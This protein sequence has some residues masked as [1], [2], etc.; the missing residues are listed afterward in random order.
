MNLTVH[1]FTLGCGAGTNITSVDVDALAF[2]LAAFE[3]S[4]A[5]LAVS[6]E[7]KFDLLEV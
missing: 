6:V 7:G 5:A 1:A 3:S 2:V 4:A